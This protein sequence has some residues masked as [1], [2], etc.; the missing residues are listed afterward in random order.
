MAHQIAGRFETLGA[1]WA[2]K[3]GVI[4]AAGAV[5]H[6]QLFFIM[7]EGATHTAARRAFVVGFGQL[8]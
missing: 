2:R 3:E 7:D 6:L 8:Q 5:V 1:V 4:E